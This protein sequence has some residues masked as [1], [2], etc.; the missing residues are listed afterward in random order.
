M[1]SIGPYLIGRMFLI[2][3]CNFLN[4]AKIYIGTSGWNYKH[5]ENGI[6]YPADLPKAKQLGFFSQIFNT[7]ELN[8][9][10]YHLP[11]IKTFQNWRKRTSQDFIFAVKASRYITHIKKLKGEGWSRFISRAKYLKEKLGPILFQLPPNWKKNEKRLKAFVNKLS[12]KYRYV[13]EF[14]H[15]S[16]FCDEI[17]K[18]LQKKN[19]GLCI[20]NSARFP[21][22]ERIT[23]NFVYLR[24]HGPNGLYNSKYSK[25]QLQKWA[26]KIKRWHRRGLDIYVYFNNDFQGYAIQNARELTKLI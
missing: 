8:A 6:F 15:L 19:C 3:I 23:S 13:F 7:V 18:I 2:L 16:W 14:R 12:S 24:F 10:F 21:A 9:S 20:A 22:R 1:R 4:M 25:S 5:W 26:S 11:R 17:Y